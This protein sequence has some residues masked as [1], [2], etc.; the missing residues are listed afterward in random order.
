MLVCEFGG[1]IVLVVNL[2]LLKINRRELP[3]VFRIIT[4]EK[5][6]TKRGKGF[7]DLAT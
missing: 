4:P 2:M 6:E 1:A 3:P 5:D 7:P